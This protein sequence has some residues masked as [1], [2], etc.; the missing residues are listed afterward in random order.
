MCTYFSVHFVMFIFFYS[1]QKIIEAF[2]H[3]QRSI[4][5]SLMMYKG[6][7]GDKFLFRFFFPIIRQNEKI[8][9]ILVVVDF[10]SDT[11]FVTFNHDIGIL[12]L[13]H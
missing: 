13:K 8:L 6:E 7:T 11:L 4:E 3:Q 2:N 5:T 10:M 9:S 12:L 1:F